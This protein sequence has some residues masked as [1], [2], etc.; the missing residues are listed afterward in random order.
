MEQD[1]AYKRA[2]RSARTGMG[3]GTTSILMIFTVL[4]FATLAM[5]SM[6][7]V[8]SNATIQTR[9]TKGVIALAAA[10]GEAAE[11]AA[12]LDEALAG[13]TETGDAYFAAAEAAATGLGFAAGPEERQVAYTADE[14]D[15]HEVVMVLELQ[16]PG[17][18]ARFTVVQMVSQY[19]GTWQP[20]TGA[21]LFVP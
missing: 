6:S 21:G 1:A 13:I 17:Q 7:T 14:G 4:A 8:M 3:V 18:D 2:G 10:E 5:L 19:T 12:A 9:G 16:E 20:E 11:K 15:S